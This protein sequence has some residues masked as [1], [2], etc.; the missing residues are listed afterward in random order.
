MRAS[1]LVPQASGEAGFARQQAAH[2]M[3]GHSLNASPQLN[4]RIDEAQSLNLQ[5][6]LQ[7]SDWHSKVQFDDLAAS[8]PALFEDPSRNEGSARNH[9]LSGQWQRRFA[10]ERKLELKFIAGEAVND[11]DNQTY[12]AGQPY[13]RSVGESQDRSFTQSG[14]FSQLVGDQH[15][16]SAGWELESR[17]RDDERRIT[18]LGADQL[19][20]IDGLPLSARI[21]RQAWYLQD[22]WELSEQWLLYGGLRREAITTRSDTLDIPVRNHSQV[23]SPLLHVNFKPDAKGRDV[24]RASITRSYKAPDLYAMLARPTLN[25]IYPLP[26]QGN[27]SVA[28]DRVGNPLLRPELAT[29]L[30]LAYERYFSGGGMF[31]IGVFHRR[32]KDLVRNITTLENPAWATVPR[33][34]SR[35]ENMSRA[36]SSGIELEWKGSAAQLLPGW[37]DPKTRLDFK[38]SLNYYKSKVDAVPLPNSRLDGQQPWSG[39]FGFDYRLRDLPLAIGGNLSYTPAYVTQQTMSQALALSHSRAIDLY[40]QWTLNPQTSLRLGATNA[41]SHWSGRTTSSNDGAMLEVFRKSRPS[42]TVALDVKL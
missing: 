1:R 16:L 28:A 15:R 13:R 31:S 32:V 35:P 14:K 33:W 2:D 10:S 4:W 30:D 20:G 21:A 22:E 38:G 37:I 24:V 3:W 41:A 29:G 27:D 18:V 42:Y 34:V 19:P 39:T 5:A 11:F 12:R 9:R 23:L 25:S 17:R 36:S 40:A 6:F 26:N 7:R 8:S